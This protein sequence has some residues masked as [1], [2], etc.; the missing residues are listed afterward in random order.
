[1]GDLET[2][3]KARR[4]LEDLYL[5]VP[6]ASVNLTFEDLSKV[7]M[8]D[9]SEPLPN[10]SLTKLP[11]LDFNRAFEN[12]VIE[13]N[14]HTNNHVYQDYRRAQNHGHHVMKENDMLHGRHSDRHHNLHHGYGGHGGY[15]HREMDGHGNHHGHVVGGHYPYGSHGRMHVVGNSMSY[16]HDMSQMSGISTVST[17]GRHYPGRRRPGIPHSNICTICTTYIYLF[18]HRCLVCGRAYCRQ[19]VR[20][21]MGEMPEGRKCVEC[22]GKRFSQ[23]Y[24]KRAGEM[25][26][27]MGYP[28]RVKQQELIWAEKGPRRVVAGQSSMM[29]ST[30]R[31]PSPIMAHSLM[32]S[33][34]SPY[35][36]S[37]HHPLPL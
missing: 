2:L 4:E 12:I 25:G 33:P 21:G 37:P 20:M 26:C 14:Y 16:D 30:S 6:D 10:S 15:H 11:S 19:C 17:G 35:S 8:S 29:M 3:A 34:Y 22:L 13:N 23:R 7:M 5:G 36:S 31:S 1:M 24:I 28:S 27:C 18:R 32:G 9:V